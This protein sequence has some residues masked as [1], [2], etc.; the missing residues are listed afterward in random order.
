MTTLN[1]APSFLFALVHGSNLLY[2]YVEAMSK[3]ILCIFVL[4]DSCRSLKNIY[5]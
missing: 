2:V 4:C 1:I 5:L 3:A